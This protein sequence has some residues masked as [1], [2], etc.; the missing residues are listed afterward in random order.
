MYDVGTMVMVRIALPKRARHGSSR[1]TD[2]RWNEDGVKIKNH[3]AI[4]IRTQEQ[5]P[6]GWMNTTVTYSVD[7]AKCFLDIAASRKESV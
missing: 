3:V 5:T 1:E 4:S 6:G 7:A 2:D